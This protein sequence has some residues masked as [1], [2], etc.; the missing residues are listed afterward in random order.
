MEP[1]GFVDDVE[2]RSMRSSSVIESEIVAQRARRAQNGGERRLQVMRDRG[3]QRRAQAD[4]LRP[5][6]CPVDIGNELDALDRQRRLIGERVEQPLLLRRQQ[7]PVAAVAVEADHADGGAAGSQ[8]H[9]EPL[10]AGQRVGAAAGGMIVLPGPAGGG[11]IGIVQRIVRRI[12]G[13]DG[14]RAFFRQQQHDADLQH[15]GEL[16]AV[17]HSTSSSVPVPASFL[18]KR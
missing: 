7:R 6:A 17:A 10:G 15:R 18:E 3:E 4:R 5:R 14:D 9:I 8:R 13:L 16:N 11:D 1:L 12:A 2:S